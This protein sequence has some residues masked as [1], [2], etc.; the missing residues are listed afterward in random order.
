MHGSASVKYTVL[1]NQLESFSFL[2]FITGRKF[3]KLGSALLG[4][5]CCKFKGQGCLHR[6]QNCMDFKKNQTLKLKA[7]QETPLGSGFGH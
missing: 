5:A 2:F 1:V 7:N 3:S 4:Q 6:H